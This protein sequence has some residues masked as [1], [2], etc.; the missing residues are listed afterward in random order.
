MMNEDNMVFTMLTKDDVEDSKKTK[1]PKITNA[2]GFFLTPMLNV[3]YLD[4]GEKASF[5]LMSDGIYKYADK[6]SISNAARLCF[7]YRKVEQACSNLRNEVYEN[8]AG[9]NLSLIAIFVSCEL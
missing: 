8:G 1:N 6:E 9:D 5:L 7:I 3:T 4:Y 2:I